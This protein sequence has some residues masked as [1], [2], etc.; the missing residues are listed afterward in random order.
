VGLAVVTRIPSYMEA[1][2]AVGALRSGG[3]DAELFDG[4]FGQ[5]EAPVIESLGGFRIMAPEEQ[6]A[7][8]RDV[9]KLLRA[10][11][12][13]GEPDEMGPW[14]ASLGETRRTRGLGMRL[15]AFLLISAPFLL[16]VV[17]RLV[18]WLTPPP[19]NP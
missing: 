17:V 14:S 9:L 5:V 7:A 3:I 10:S 19:I 12:G 11:P 6:V 8:A 4:N 13:L 1:Q 2:I 15:L 18:G 16:W